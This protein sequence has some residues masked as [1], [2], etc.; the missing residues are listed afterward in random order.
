MVLGF[1]TRNPTYP[2]PASNS[3]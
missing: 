3:T 1:A 2:D